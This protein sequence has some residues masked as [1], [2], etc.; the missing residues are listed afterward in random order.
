MAKSESEH[1]YAIWTSPVSGLT[2]EYS[3]PAFHEIDFSV[4]EGYRR[5]PHGG[6]EVGGI[7]F[8]RIDKESV[9]VDAFRPIDCE[10]A[11]GP[12]FIPSE[13]DIAKL[14]EQLTNYKSDSELQSLQPV[15]VFVAHTRSGLEVND[16]EFAL[17]EDLF[18]GPGKVLLLVKPERFQPT[19]FAFFVRASDGGLE[20]D[21]P[22]QASI[23]PLPSRG[24]AQDPLPE[25]ARPQSVRHVESPQQVP[26]RQRSEPVVPTTR[27]PEARPLVPAGSAA[28]GLPSIDEI[29]SRR[30]R[31]QFDAPGFQEHDRGERFAYPAKRKW[32]S[33]FRITPLGL[34]AALLGCC[35]GYA[36]YLQLPSAV[37]PLQIEPQTNGLLLSWS[38][39]QTSHADL[40]AMR[41]ND[42]DPAALSSEDKINGRTQITATG[43]N[44]KIELI[45]RHWL[46]DSRGITRYV[47]AERP[48]QGTH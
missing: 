36:I 1:D 47:R 26:P 28:G 32:P 15:G 3:R 38:A 42:G 27:A 4:N 2:V 20:G 21:V 37:I 24:T 29:R 11:A 34:A 18:P 8:G 44:V 13:R 40:A 41:I 19:R 33:Q 25:P 31:A 14:N 39:E 48:P 45:A 17:F 10:H 12:S 30:A 46:R 43:D 7:L 9:R 23:L 35:V 6:I 22:E 16:R 5:I